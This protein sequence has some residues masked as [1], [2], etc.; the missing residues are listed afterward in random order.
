MVVVLM[1]SVDYCRLIDLF[2]R[3]RNEFGIA[4]N[5]ISPPETA[6]IAAQNY[7]ISA[8]NGGIFHQQSAVTG[9]AYAS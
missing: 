7:E 1:I 2:A 3:W 6:V 9:Y 4:Y 5:N 8:V